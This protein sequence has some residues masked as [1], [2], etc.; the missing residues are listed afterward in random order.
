MTNEQTIKTILEI[1]NQEYNGNI[2]KLIQ[3]Y[4]IQI[5]GC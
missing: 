1:A 4:N 5:R 2:T 3:N